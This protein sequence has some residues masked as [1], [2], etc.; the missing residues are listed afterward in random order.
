MTKQLTGPTVL[1]ANSVLV[2]LY[3]DTVV[4]WFSFRI[5]VLVLEIYGVY[6]MIT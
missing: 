4:N 2:T 5:L 3:S 1:G 6:P